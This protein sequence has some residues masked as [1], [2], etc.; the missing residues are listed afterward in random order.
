MI[1][2]LRLLLGLALFAAIVWW[3]VPDAEVLRR[4]GARLE[5]RPLWL[6]L[7]LV[8]TFA[9]SV[10]TSARWQHLA[11]GTGGTRLPFI[12]YFY[13]LVLT[14]V[15]G[16]VSSTLVMD[17]VGRGVALRAAGSERDLGHAL[18]QAVLERIFDLVLPMMVLGWALLAWRGGWDASATLGSFVG[19]CVAFA[20]LAAVTLRPLVRLALWSYD[21]GRGALARVRGRAVPPRSEPVSFSHRLAWTIGLQSLVRYLIVILNFWAIA[22]A[23][24]VDL[25]AWQIAAST[26]FGQVAGMLGVTPGALGI[27]EAGWVGGLRWVEVDGD[28][29]ALFVLSQRLVATIYFSILVVASYPLLRRARARAAGPR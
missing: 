2:A 9:A 10:V 22:L 20:A 1:R 27:Q 3:L 26:P 13:S 15:L 18:T 23:V 25:S 14:R 5:L 24:G 16:Q 21:A 12:A 6:A 17:L 4:I 8:A 28:A 7:G 11:E 19:V 29:I